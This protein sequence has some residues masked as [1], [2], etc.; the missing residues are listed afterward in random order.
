VTAIVFSRFPLISASLPPVVGHIRPSKQLAERTLQCVAQFI[1]N[2]RAV[3]SGAIVVEPQQCGIADT[4]FL[5]QAVQRPALLRKDLS[6]PAGDHT[7]RVAGASCLCQL[8]WLYKLWFTL[9][10][11]RS[12]LVVSREGLRIPSLQWKRTINCRAGVLQTAPG[13]AAF[14]A[15]VQP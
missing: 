2:V 8:K 4:R 3:H 10:R 14:A 6:K 13:F 11:C 15:E 5:S 1:Q 9:G 7:S 12:R